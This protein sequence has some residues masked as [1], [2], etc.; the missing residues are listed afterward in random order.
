MYNTD[1]SKRGFTL[2][3]LL[4][5]IAIIGMLATL[6][7]FGVNSARG[8]ALVVSAQSDLHDIQTAIFFLEQDTAQSP[9]HE[10][11]KCGGPTGN[12]ER[13][14]FDCKTGL[15]CNDPVQPYIGWSG[16]YYSGST[17]DPWG[18]TY[19]YDGDYNCNTS[20]PIATG[21]EGYPA[22]GTAY[23]VVYSAGPNHSAI[24]TYDSDNVV[25]VL[26]Q[27]P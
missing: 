17:E 23:R 14:I 26:C 18:D 7:L 6:V 25:L 19:V 9:N 2:I 16:P 12:N 13:L 3:E 11:L 15:L 24:N 21:C 20:N 10:V 22:L 1:M 5:V 27:N 4:V 8:R